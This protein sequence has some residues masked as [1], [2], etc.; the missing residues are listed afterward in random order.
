[1]RRRAT[2]RRSPPG[3]DWPARTPDSAECQSDLAVVERNLGNFY[4]ALDKKDK[5]RTAYESELA[6][7]KP[8][9]EKY[10]EV[11]EYQS[12]LASC[13]GRPG[14]GLFGLRRHAD[15]RGVLQVVACH[16]QGSGRKTPRRA[17]LPDLSGRGLQ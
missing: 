14:S 17:E 16:L 15:R 7:C 3:N 2:S 1:M 9:A 10:P 12:S 4:W 11:P 8:L 5:A 13:Y 6:I